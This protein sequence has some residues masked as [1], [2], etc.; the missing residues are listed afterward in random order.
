M[1][2]YTRRP[3][4]LSQA[5][6]DPE[7]YKSKVSEFLAR[8]DSAISDVDVNLWLPRPYNLTMA[9]A[10]GGRTFVLPRSIGEVNEA[11]VEHIRA[12]AY[13]PTEVVTAQNPYD[14]SG[15]EPNDID[16]VTV[17]GKFDIAELY[18]MFN[19]IFV[20]DVE[21]QWADPCLA[22]PVFA[23]VQLQRQ[24]L[25]TDS[26]WSDW[27]NV[28]RTKIDQHRKLFEIVQDIKDLPPGGLKVHMLHFDEKYVQI[29][30]LQPQAYQIASA[31]EEWFPPLLHR[32]FLD[33]QRKMTLE[34]RREAKEAEREERSKELEERRNRRSETRLGTAGRSTG[35][36]LSDSFGGMDGSFGSRDT[37]T[38][39]DRDRTGNRT[40]TGIYG[41][42]D[43][44]SRRRSRSRTTTATDQLNMYDGMIERP[45]ETRRGL[46]R[47]SINDVYD[48]YNDLLLTR[49]TDFAKIRELLVFWAH[50]DTVEPTKTYR[51]RIRLGVFNPVA[52]TNQLSEQD[53]SR[54]NQVVLWSDFS[55]TTEAV[56]I[57][58]RLYFFAKNIRD[59]DK[60]ITVQ[61]SKLT[62]GHWYSHD[63]PVK[64]GEV[65]GDVIEPEPEKP[66]R[67]VSRR[68]TAAVRP[69]DKTQMPETIDYSTGAVMVDA[70]AVNDWSGERALSTRHYYD[71]LYS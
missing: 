7:P 35:G 69:E 68:L 40:G 64:Q 22:K 53:K 43:S 8:F 16:L 5:P 33:F 55:D 26:T 24:E 49:M 21:E 23:A 38:R 52:G 54:K 61:V 1:I 19:E 29:D 48:E 2:I 28:P 27:L 65:I 44:T 37:R 6:E 13:V 46:R 71:M 42:G 59:V 18:D 4:K 31:N 45:G 15:N 62:L 10:I 56:E 20:E 34:E 57:P 70:V 12:V 60:T 47:P 51:Y 32:K 58:G 14:K 50:D 36:R 41:E 3:T 66:E 25:N 63:F 11:A 30:L 17:E 67:G 39:R 9:K